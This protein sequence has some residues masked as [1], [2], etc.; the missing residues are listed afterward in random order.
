R[1][2]TRL[3]SDW[4]SDVCSSDLKG[5]QHENGA[6]SRPPVQF[7][8]N[9][10]GSFHGCA[11]LSYSDFHFWLL[12]GLWHHAEGRVARKRAAGGYHLDFSAAGAGGYG[13]GD[14]GTRNDFED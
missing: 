8:Q 4:S 3:V 10:N 6:G 14:F 12:A 7:A 2:H 9:I 5:A 13:G 11:P 1:R